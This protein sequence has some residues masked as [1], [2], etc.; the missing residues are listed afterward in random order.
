MN[1]MKK[2]SDPEGVNLLASILICYREISAVAYEPKDKS[3]K[4][5]FALEKSMDEEDFKELAEYLAESMNT[6]LTISGFYGTKIDFTMETQGKYAFLHIIRELETLT[7]GELTLIVTLLGERLGDS[8]IMSGEE[9]L[10]DE[11]LEV[12]EETLERMLMSAR[13]TDLRGRLVGVREGDAVM[14][15]D[16]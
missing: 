16:K 6:Y 11:L 9:E 7:K 3:V 10:D 12:H 4:I 13:M 8:L 14:V 15:Y 2:N 5:T 1:L